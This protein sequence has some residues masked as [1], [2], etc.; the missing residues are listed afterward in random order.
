MDSTLQHPAP[1]LLYREMTISDIPGGLR[2]CRAARWNQLEADWRVFLKARPGGCRVAERDGNVV[3]T[4]ATLPF[5]GRFSWISMV[6]VDPAERGAGI[7]TRLIEET[8]D[9][10]RDESC[11]RLDATPAGLPLYKRHGFAEE[12]PVLRLTT[13][14]EEAR[15]RPQAAGIR[16]MI[17][18]DFQAVLSLDAIAF[19]ADRGFLLRNLFERDRRYAWVAVDGSEIT[20]YS[21]GRRGFLFDHLGPIVARDIE[22][23]RQLASACLGAAHEVKVGIDVPQRNASWTRWLEQIG[24]VEERSLLRMFRGEN[25]YPGRVSGVYAIAGP[26]FG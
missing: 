8:L 25:R 10:L 26:E 9:L 18:E 12:Y 14:V 20:G 3:G 16:P 15:V 21:L 5:S 23:A 1:G 24:F 6:L 4:I 19:G 11:L 7:G 13:V 22:I 2:L 17:S